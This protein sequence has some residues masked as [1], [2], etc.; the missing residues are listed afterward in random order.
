MAGKKRQVR[1]KEKPSKYIIHTKEHWAEH[2]EREMESPSLSEVILTW[3][4]LSWGRWISHIFCTSMLSPFFFLPSGIPGFMAGSSSSFPC[5]YILEGGSLL[6][7]L[8]VCQIPCCRLRWW[9]LLGRWFP[10]SSS[11]WTGTGGMTGMINVSWFHPSQGNDTSWCSFCLISIV[12]SRFWSHVVVENWKYVCTTQIAFFPIPIY[13]TQTTRNTHNRDE[14]WHL[15]SLSLEDVLRGDQWEKLLAP[16]TAGN[17]PASGNQ[18]SWE[19][20]VVLGTA[21][22]W[23]VGRTHFFF[24]NYKYRFVLVF[25]LI[26]YFNYKHRFSCFS[27][28]HH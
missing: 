10:P 2:L 17:D 18:F 8:C 3:S 24:F 1:C 9:D 28:K 22:M 14:S 19:D 6:C 25:D 21:G 23:M 15:G 5:H 27:S 20:L 4:V 26:I 12:E 7:Q 16:D 11:L 13:T